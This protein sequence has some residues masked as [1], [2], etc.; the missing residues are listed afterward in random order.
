[1]TKCGNERPADRKGEKKV[2][3]KK[4]KLDEIAD[5][6]ITLTIYGGCTEGDRMTYSVRGDQRAVIAYG[7]VSQLI[8]YSLG[9]EV[10]LTA[11]GIPADYKNRPFK[12]NPSDKFKDAILSI[13]AEMTGEGAGIEKIIKAKG[14][15]HGGYT[16]QINGQRVTED[17]YA[18][19]YF[20]E[21]T[22]VM[23][24]DKPVPKASKEVTEND[25]PLMRGKNPVKMMGGVELVVTAIIIPGDEYQDMAKQQDTTRYAT[26]DKAI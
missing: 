24:G 1:M 22:F 20:Q 14:G 25:T 6:P 13:N 17:S 2:K 21:M 18:N 11:K 16:V 8:Q 23:D 10:T 19:S 9:Q 15:K 26:L 3:K 12:R 4:F 7:T 5:L